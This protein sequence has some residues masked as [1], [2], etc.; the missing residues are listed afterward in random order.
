MGI[1]IT[2]AAG[3]LGRQVAEFA[4]ESADPA[5]LILVTRRPDALADLA[6]RGAVVRHGDFD[7]PATLPGAFAGGTRM[8]LISTDA[9]G[10]RVAQHRA[11]IDAAVA[12]GVAHVL[13]TS[14]VNPATDGP[15][16][17]VATDH[18]ATERALR[19]SGLTW[20]MLRNSV[21]SDFLVPPA[22]AAL[23][24]GAHV[25]NA[26]DGRVGY[27]TRE[28]CARAA[29]AVL[30][31]TGHENVVYDITG[32]EAVDADRLAAAFAAAGGAPVA[33]QRVDDAT[34]EGILVDAGTPAPMAAVLAAFG[35]ATREGLLDV[36]SP[37]VRDLTGRGPAPLDGVRAAGLAAAAGADG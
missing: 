34:F 4:L 6:A 35:R 18:D 30:T 7:D 21:Y 1:I 32:P 17:I 16:G 24:H 22:Q 29:A 3:H 19:D 8:L 23:A 11:A 28:D 31:G 20:T 12:A 14:V 36:V 27:V 26:G 5:D 9:V 25:T 15:L 37:A 33:V 13:Y 10:Q 2:G